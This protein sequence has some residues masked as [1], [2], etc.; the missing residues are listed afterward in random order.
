VCVSVSVCVC[1]FSL[2][3]VIS[4]EKFYHF[5]L[6]LPASVTSIII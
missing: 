5:K 6:P 4:V 1:V 2:S 3:D